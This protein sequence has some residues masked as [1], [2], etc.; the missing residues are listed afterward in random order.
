M[1]FNLTDT[2]G[3]SVWSA[4]TLE[5]SDLAK[6]E[7]ILEQCT[8][9]LKNISVLEGGKYTW[10]QD[11]IP[12]NSEGNKFI[13]D[14][15]NSKLSKVLKTFCENIGINEIN[16]L[17]VLVHT[18]NEETYEKVFSIYG[19]NV[20]YN[21]VNAVEEIIQWLSDESEILGKL[22]ESG[23]DYDIEDLPESSYLGQLRDKMDGIVNRLDK[24]KKVAG[25]NSY[26]KVEEVIEALEGNIVSLESK[27]KTNRGF[28]DVLLGGNSQTDVLIQK[29]LGPD[30]TSDRWT[31][32][33]AFLNSESKSLLHSDY[34]STKSI[35]GKILT[36]IDN[37]D[38]KISTYRSALCVL[39]S[40]VNDT[41]NTQTTFPNTSGKVLEDLDNDMSMLGDS[42]SIIKVLNN[43]L[44]YARSSLMLSAGNVDRV[45]VISVSSSPW[46]YSGEGVFTL[47]D[48]PSGMT[49][50]ADNSVINNC[51]EG[52][53]I[54]FKSS[55]N[56]TFSS[57]SLKGVLYK[58]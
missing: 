32:L 44:Y 24:F 57:G 43:L 27:A 25:S 33:E 40:A 12:T 53:N 19:E 37:N 16:D 22:I 4:K 56:I 11:I 46:N 21:L 13:A 39:F 54:V 45:Q 23:E 36:K 34:I 29:F 52:K 58:N 51:V 10:G 7:Y 47:V 2:S 50:K 3:K 9:F 55:I 41:L 1:A 31:A 42:G 30:N 6:L 18:G 14:E 35:L 20:Q 49:I 8:K 26:L 5:S 28:I 38:T 48:V 15:E 17:S